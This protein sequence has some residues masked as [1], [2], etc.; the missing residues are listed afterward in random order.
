M[1]TTLAC[2]RGYADCIEGAVEKGVLY[3]IG[4]YHAGEVKETEIMQKAYEM[5]TQI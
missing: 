2:F 1:D 5:G 4:V 3:G